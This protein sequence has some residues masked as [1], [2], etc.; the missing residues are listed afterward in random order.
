MHI[1]DVY[2]NTNLKAFVDKDHMPRD[3]YWGLV[4][5]PEFNWFDACCGTVL[6][7]APTS[8]N[9]HL[10]R[11]EWNTARQSEWQDRGVQ[12]VITESRA[13][14]VIH[15]RF[16]NTTTDKRLVFPTEGLEERFVFFWNFCAAVDT[17]CF[18]LKIDQMYPAKKKKRPLRIYIYIIYVVSAA[19]GSGLP[20]LQLSRYTT[21]RTFEP[22]MFTASNNTAHMC[23]VHVFTKT[24]ISDWGSLRVLVARCE[25]VGMGSYVKNTYTAS[26]TW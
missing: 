8:V 14:A 6:L 24:A 10:L 16:I 5:T 11:F 12:V 1:L 19:E 2:T 4:L 13:M 9:T 21:Q 7:H 18:I 3:G 25:T 17:E 26:Q 23:N 22:K 20:E 15:V